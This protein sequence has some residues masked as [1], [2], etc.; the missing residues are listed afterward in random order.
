MGMS[1][2]GL[3]GG[4]EVNGAFDGTLACTDIKNRDRC[5]LSDNL[6]SRYSGLWGVWAALSKQ[7][8]SIYRRLDQN[9]PIDHFAFLPQLDLTCLANQNLD[10]DPGRL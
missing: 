5:Y 3:E 7:S 2:S 9:T 6:P 4:G 1:R 10:T 8:M